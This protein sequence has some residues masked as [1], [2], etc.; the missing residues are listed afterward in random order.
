MLRTYFLEHGYPVDIINKIIHNS[1]WLTRD[2]LKRDYVQEIFDD[3][4]IYILVINYDSN[5]AI[6]GYAVISEYTTP[7]EKN[8][9][10]DIKIL[11]CAQKPTV[12]TRFSPRR[13]SG[14]EMMKL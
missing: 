2:K 4:D 14:K 6:R 7:D 12:K 9:F 3:D 1:K 10:Y 13:N 8:D 11:C 5:G